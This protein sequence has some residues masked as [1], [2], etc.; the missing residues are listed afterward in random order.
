M[1]TLE[2]KLAG[3]WIQM[4]LHLSVRVCEYHCWRL[5]AGASGT[6]AVI[7]LCRSAICHSWPHFRWSNKIIST[8][9]WRTLP[10]LSMSLFCIFL[11]S[12]HFVL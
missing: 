12:S 3:W 2:T 1:V 7:H 8:Y 6:C 5:R 11:D 10:N 9:R 4:K